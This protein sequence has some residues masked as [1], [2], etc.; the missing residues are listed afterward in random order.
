MKFIAP[1]SNLQ[2]DN[3]FV[4]QHSFLRIFVIYARN[5]P[6]ANVFICPFE[7]KKETIFNKAYIKSRTHQYMLYS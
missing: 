5:N 2:S 7:R 1:L 4:S 6:M 3:S